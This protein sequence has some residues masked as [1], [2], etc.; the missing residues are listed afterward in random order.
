MQIFENLYHTYTNISKIYPQI[1]TKI[2][3]ID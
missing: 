1:N 2:L 3:K